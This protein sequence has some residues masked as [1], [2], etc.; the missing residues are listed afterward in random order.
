[1]ALVVENGS[2]LASAN[3]FVSVAYVDAYHAEGGNATWTGTDALK[4]AAIIRATRYLS[5]SY[6]WAGL[7]RL[8]RRQ[9]LA[10]PRVDV[11]DQEGYAVPFDAVP[12]EIERAVSEIALRELVAPGAM[13]PD[14]TPSER[15]KSEKVGSI[16]VEYDLS[17]TDA[18]SVRPVL[19]VVRDL[20][21]PLLASGGGSMV[22]GSA[23][24]V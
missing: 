16:A 12:T 14:Y 22:Q 24:R 8:D 6:A 21:G 3:G 1:M 5:N 10:W 15:V 7:R 19:L 17:R 13:T 2:G 23:V 9:A 11:Y 20:I 18:E 4:E